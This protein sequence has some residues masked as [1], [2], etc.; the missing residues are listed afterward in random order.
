MEVSKDVNKAFLLLK[1]E[2]QGDVRR[3]L[4]SCHVNI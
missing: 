2:L 3:E 4:Y 1:D